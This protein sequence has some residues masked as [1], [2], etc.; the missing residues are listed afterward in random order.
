MET[1]NTLPQDLSRSRDLLFGLPVPFSITTAD[2]NLLWPFIDNVYSIRKAR[3]VRYPVP[4]TIRYVSCR[5]KRVRRKGVPSGQSGRA[6]PKRVKPSCGVTF[7]MLEYPDHVEFYS[8][9]EQT[10]NHS[11]TLDESD[12]IKRNGFLR[13]LILKEVARG[14]APATIISALRGTKD[15]QA[16]VLR[17]VGGT[18]LTRQDVINIS[19][20]KDE[21]ESRDAEV[22]LATDEMLEKVRARF[23][24]VLEYADSLEGSARNRV[25]NAWEQRITA[26]AEAFIGGSLNEWLE[27]NL[28]AME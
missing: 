7:R 11:H 15:A 12:A 27:R 16:L 5:F 3:V 17:V 18:H 25:L 28:P 8:S 13:K 14:Y 24:E 4:H 20:S 10:T 6:P 1:L 9:G 2:Y 22:K 26:F 21:H 23:A 19:A